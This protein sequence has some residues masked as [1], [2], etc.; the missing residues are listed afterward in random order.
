[1]IINLSFTKILPFL[2]LNLFLLEYSYGMFKLPHQPHFNPNNLVDEQI[3]LIEKTDKE[4][5]SLLAKVDEFEE[6]KFKINKENYSPLIKITKFVKILDEFIHQQKH[7]PFPLL[8]ITMDFIYKRNTNPFEEPVIIVPNIILHDASKLFE[9]PETI[10]VGT[11]KLPK[12]AKDYKELFDKLKLLWFDKAGDDE[13]DKE[14]LNKLTE[15]L[16]HKTFDELFGDDILFGNP[17]QLQQPSSST[18][19]V[20]YQKDKTHHNEQILV[21]HSQQSSKKDEDSPLYEYLLKLRKTVNNVLKQIFTEFVVGLD[22]NSFKRMGEEF[23]KTEELIREYML[24]CYSIRYPH[25]FNRKKEIEQL[26]NFYDKLIE[27]KDFKINNYWTKHVMDMINNKEG[28][29]IAIGNLKTIELEDIKELIKNDYVGLDEEFT[30]SRILDD[31]VSKLEN[32]NDI[33]NIVLKDLWKQNEK[34]VRTFHLEDDEKEEIEALINKLKRFYEKINELSTNL[35]NTTMKFYEHPAYRLWNVHNSLLKASNEVYKNLNKM[36]YTFTK[37][38]DLNDLKSQN[39]KINQEESEIIEKH[40]NGEI[41]LNKEQKA[42]LDRFKERF[43]TWIVAEFWLKKAIKDVA[44]FFEKEK[45][46]NY[47]LSYLNLLADKIEKWEDLPLV[48]LEY[49][50]KYLNFKQLNSKISDGKNDDKKLEILSVLIRFNAGKV[51]LAY[52]R[53]K[54]IFKAFNFDDFDKEKSQILAG[55]IES[56]IKSEADKV[57]QE[58]IHNRIY[59]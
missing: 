43:E 33:R 18:E 35:L 12:E 34:K 44:K 23:E 42:R 55:T 29:D 48:W 51:L 58:K 37:T 26:H 59:G 19:I 17:Q 39:F 9:K 1:M 57:I 22:Y 20:P 2:A 50:E 46:Y 53:M 6:D 5:R 36:I 52:T 13:S 56:K 25:L 10:W 31:K 28:F 38:F 54:Q 15:E 49:E 3:K 4:F 45:S 40:Q 30:P 14:R 21:K 32:N 7:F 16:E 47:T 27:N 11:K 8:V 24:E 41:N